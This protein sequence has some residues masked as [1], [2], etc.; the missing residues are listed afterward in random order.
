MAAFDKREEAQEQEKTIPVF[1]VLKNN[2][3]LKNIFLLDNLPSVP[4]LKPFNPL[5]NSDRVQEF[6]E[7]LLVGRH[8]DCNIMLEHPSKK[9]LA[10]GLRLNYTEAVALIATQNV[11]SAVPS[12]D[13]FLLIVDDRIPGE[14]RYGAGCITL[15]HGRKA[16]TLKVTSTGDRPIQVGSHYHFIE[17]NPF[18]VFDRSKAHGMRLNIPAGT[19]TRFEDLRIVPF[20]VLV[21]QPGDKKSV[22]L[23][24]IGGKQVIRGGNNIADGPV[25]DANV[26]SVMKA[27]RTREFRH[28]EEPNASEGVITEGGS[29]TYTISREAYAN[30]YGPTVGD[31]VRLGDTDLFAEIEKDFAVYGDECVFGGGKVIRDGMGQASGYPAADCLDT[32][33]TN[34]LIIDYTGIFKAD[35]GIKGS[36]IVAIGKAGNPD[37]MDG[38]SDNMII[39]VN[40]EVIAGEGMIV[41]A[42]AIDCHVH[43]I[44]PQLAYEAISSGS[45]RALKQKL[46]RNFLSSV[47]AFSFNLVCSCTFCV[48]LALNFS[49]SFCFL[50]AALS[51]VLK[52]KGVDKVGDCNFEEVDAFHNDGWWEGIVT[53]ILQDSRYSVFFRS[54]REQIDFPDSDLRLHREWVHGIWVP[55]LEQQPP[56][57][58]EQE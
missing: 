25:D 54:S 52:L 33:I 21:G 17:V 16:V 2:T 44:C 39:G 53:A 42:G 5:K 24:R 19:A 31:K 58:Q 3:I 57:P 29:F 11:G 56:P 1:T 37:V 10:R 46:C 18:L 7:T 4:D 13:K 48:S 49:S 12:L 27:V 23:V 35:I 15:N 34:A 41:T 22:T 36:V 20:F 8:P 50:L 14:L 6:E 51:F 9:R 38:V 28:S 40:T 30:M 47:P 32:V 26:T 43:F 55:P 45:G